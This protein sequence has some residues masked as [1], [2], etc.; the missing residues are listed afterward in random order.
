MSAQG[1]DESMLNVLYYYY[2]YSIIIIIM[3]FLAKCF[4]LARVWTACDVHTKVQLVLCRNLFYEWKF[5]VGLNSP[6]RCSCAEFDGL[7]EH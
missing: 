4:Q 1:D 5:L 7:W 2:Y 6:L 3:T